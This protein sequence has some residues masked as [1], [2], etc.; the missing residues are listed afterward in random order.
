MS[1]VISKHKQDGGVPEQF[2]TYKQTIYSTDSIRNHITVMRNHITELEVVAPSVT[3][4]N[5]QKLDCLAN[6]VGCR[7]GVRDDLLRLE[8]C[9]EGTITERGACIGRGGGGGGSS[10]WGAEIRAINIRGMRTVWAAGR[11]SNGRQRPKQQW[12]TARLGMLMSFCLLK[13]YEAE[14]VDEFWYKSVNGLQELVLRC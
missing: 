14:H 10:V 1:T 5:V 8:F 6:A 13:H 2:V 3:E 4:D 7:D 9:C 11:P 12:C